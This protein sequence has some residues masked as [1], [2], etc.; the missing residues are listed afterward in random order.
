MGMYEKR[1]AR[2]EKIET[3][4]KIRSASIVCRYRKRFHRIVQKSL[5][6]AAKSSVCLPAKLKKK[7]MTHPQACHL[8][9]EHKDSCLITA[10]SN[11]ASTPTPHIFNLTV[12]VNSL[13]LPAKTRIRSSLKVLQS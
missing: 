4:E 9:G 3:D 2:T 13:K 6:Y 12:S 8:D 1:K 10:K 11:E 7:G 5:Y